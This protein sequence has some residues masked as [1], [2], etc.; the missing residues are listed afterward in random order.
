MLAGLSS[1]LQARPETPVVMVV[2]GE[3]RPSALAP[4]VEAQP[5]GRVLMFSS[6]DGQ[7]VGDGEIT[8]PGRYVI[9]A[10]RPSSFNGTPVVLELQSGRK[11]HALLPADGGPEWF[12]F[13]GRTF[14]DRTPMQ[15]RI[16]P[17]TAE[18]S[19]Q[20]SASPQAQRLSRMV[21]APCD[22]SRD[23]NRDGRCDEED[24]AILRLYGGGVS[25]V[26]P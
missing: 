18:L 7:M 14:P 17:Q 16:G 12:A 6:R 15:W 4:G 5:P 8:G 24:W 26:S 19:E 23:I 1:D 21:D 20:E 22:E 9:S 25:R 2:V 13:Q 10:S 3:I 11:R